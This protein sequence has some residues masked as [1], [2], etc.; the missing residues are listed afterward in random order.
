MRALQTSLLVIGMMLSGVKGSIAQQ[1][2]SGSEEKARAAIQ[3]TL[4]RFL[5]AWN[6]HDAH[7]FAATFTEDCDFTN[8]IGVGA[9]GRADT[10]AFHA[11]VFATI[12]KN[13]HQTGKIRSIRFLTPDL[14]AVDVDW[15]MTGATTPDGRP[16]PPR[17]GLLNWVMA[18]QS[19][20]SWLIEIFHNTDLTQFPNASK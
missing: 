11:P 6:K 3:R 19:D 5:D 17:R 10:E 15:Q 4:D 2:S 20:G 13:S 18:R 12:F 14:A 1:K 9:H 8:V 7:A 16:R